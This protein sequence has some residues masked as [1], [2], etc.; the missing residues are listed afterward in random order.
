MLMYQT[1]K[2]A[3]EKD[4]E[5]HKCMYYEKGVFSTYPFH[6]EGIFMA[7]HVNSGT[8]SLSITSNHWSPLS[9]IWKKSE[10]KS[11]KRKAWL[12]EVSPTRKAESFHSSW[13]TFDYVCLFA[14]SFIQLPSIH[15][16]KPCVGD[17]VLLC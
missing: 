12:T 13:M 1:R 11:A 8:R 5:F 2:T 10:S 6:S 16:A 3:S 14:N 7:S 17:M 4:V 15:C 9:L